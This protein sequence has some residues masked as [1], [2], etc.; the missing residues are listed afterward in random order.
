MRIRQC[1]IEAMM[2]DKLVL[3]GFNPLHLT[4]LPSA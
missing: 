1:E 4:A 2:R 3:S